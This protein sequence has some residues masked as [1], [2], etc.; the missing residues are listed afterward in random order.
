MATDAKFDWKTKWQDR[1]RDGSLIR[2]IAELPFP[3]PNGDC[4]MVEV[5]S[6][7]VYTVNANGGYRST[8]QGG[9]DLVPTPPKPEVVYWSKPEDVP[10]D[11]EWITGR[12]FDGPR[13]ICGVDAAGIRTV[14]R[15]DSWASLKPLSAKWSATRL[16]EYKPCTTTASEG[17]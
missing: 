1:T 13:R 17:V 2:R 10:G 3:F 12:D 8:V 14:A 4:L 16:G 15:H 6:G 7:A 5:D 9:L 11:A